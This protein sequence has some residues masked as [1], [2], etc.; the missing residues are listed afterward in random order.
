MGGASVTSNPA[1]GL[2]LK[3]DSADSV[4]LAYQDN[5]TGASVMKYS[6]GAWAQLGA[7][8]FSP[9]H[10]N[11]LALTLDASGTPYVVF[12]DA[13]HG[14]RLSVMILQLEIG[15][16]SVRRVFPKVKPRM[17]RLPLMRWVS[18]QLRPWTS[19][20]ATS[21]P[22][23]QATATVPA[24]NLTW[25]TAYPATATALVSSWTLSSDTTMTSQSFQTY[26]DEYC[27]SP[28]GAAV[29]LTAAGN[30]T[31]SH[32][33][34][35]CAYRATARSVSTFPQ[36]PIWSACSGLDGSDVALRLSR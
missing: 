14:A 27:N 17:F 20:K 24:S 7:A 9:G 29:T 33:D 34:R 11:A 30:T 18:P 12:S 28:S 36:D 10:V 15:T 21:S 5:G 8:S 1:A 19:R 16:S 26:S 6:A 31:Q 23:F 25:T 32:R 22:T 3:I 13:A 35:R 4:Y 2:S